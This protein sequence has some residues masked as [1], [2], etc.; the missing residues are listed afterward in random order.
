MEYIPRSQSHPKVSYMDSYISIKY[1]GIL[2]TFKV[3]FDK[4]IFI[5][6]LLKKLIHRPEPEV[7][8]NM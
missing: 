2:Q 7:I 8:F 3:L 6:V 4:I 1:A 5:F